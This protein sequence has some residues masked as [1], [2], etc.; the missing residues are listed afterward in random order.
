MEFDDVLLFHKIIEEL[1]FPELGNEHPIIYGYPIWVKRASLSSIFQ[2][3][4][5]LS[6]MKCG[7]S[8]RYWRPDEFVSIG[9]S[10]LKDWPNSFYEL[11]ARRFSEGIDSGRLHIR[12]LT[13]A[14]GRMCWEDWETASRISIEINNFLVTNSWSRTCNSDFEVIPDK[15]ISIQN[16]AND[17]GLQSMK[18]HTIL[19]RKNI[20]TVQLG[21]DGSP[22]LSKIDFRELAA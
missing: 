21:F 16:A 22:H 1:A 12:Y 20:S 15:Y 14:L 9:A 13:K 3:L 11:M 2:L 8:T 5:M 10:I 7:A 18:L 19:V 4:V 6:Y 17:L